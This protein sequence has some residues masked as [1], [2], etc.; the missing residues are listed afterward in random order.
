MPEMSQAPSPEQGQAPAQEQGGGS[1]SKLVAGVHT[2][3]MQL[4]ELINGSPAADD[5]DKQAL[6][7]LIQGYTA[8][9]EGLGSAPGQAPQG[10]PKPGVAPME[11]G[12][13]DVK[14]AM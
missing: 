5:G 8:F 6:A 12:A 14:P 11:A 9:V 1:A 4:Q 13:A 3:L 7:Q 2:G 10:A